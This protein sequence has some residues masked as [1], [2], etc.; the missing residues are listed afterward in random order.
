MLRHYFLNL[1]VKKVDRLVIIFHTFCMEYRNFCGDR[2]SV[3]GFG[4]MRFPQTADGHINKPAAEAMLDAARKAGVNYFDTAYPYHNGESEPFVGAY[5]SKL[6]RE[7]FFVATKLPV[8][9]VNS[10]EDAHTL[11]Q[12]QLGRLQLKYADFYLL[13]A[14]DR[15]RFEKMVK[16]GVVDYL[17]EEQKAGRIRHLGFSFHDG[18]DTFEL[19]VKYRKWDFCQ[20]QY[21]YMDTEEQAGERGRSLAE[22]NGIPLIIMEPVKGGSLANLPPEIVSPFTAIHSA[23]TPASWALR[24]AAGKGGVKVVLSG[25]S[26]EGQ[27][28]DNLATFS[29]F[30]P[31]DAQ[32]E[33]AVVSVRKAIKTRIRNG[34]TACRYCMP[35]PYGVD[36][37]RN[38]KVWNDWGMYG[39]KN[40]V[41]YDWKMMT[42]DKANA[43]LCRKCGA[44]E[45]K[46]PQKIHIRDDL[47][48]LGKEISSIVSAM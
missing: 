34:C 39:N 16:L 46:C 26:T 44:C 23:S 41:S 3:L 36:I 4:C 10:L 30:V 24:F 25:M 12:K 47:E 33:A 40:S 43:E 5:L 19:I 27:L 15:G 18:Y 6:P 1:Q 8:W 45:T 14:L 28:R 29:P 9:E 7:S 2:V 35:C 22:Q 11:F 13:H 42:S 20:I 21:N 17:L 32:E 38:F 48:T 31:L 37:P